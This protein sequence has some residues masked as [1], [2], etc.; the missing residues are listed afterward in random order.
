MHYFI[1]AKLR[2]LDKNRING[3]NT[4]PKQLK[5]SQNLTKLSGRNK[6]LSKKEDLS[7]HLLLLSHIIH[8][9]LRGTLNREI[10]GS[11]KHDK[12]Q[13][14]NIITICIMMQ[15]NILW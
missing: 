1:V 2:L 15:Y 11:D 9:A 13:S 8:K 12:P 4:T 3:K 6:M 10:G 5:P 14:S 7:N